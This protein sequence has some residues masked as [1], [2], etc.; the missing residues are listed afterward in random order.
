MANKKPEGELLNVAL[1]FFK[2][3]KKNRPV[4]ENNSDD[5]TVNNWSVIS[6]LWP[7][8]EADKDELKG[9]LDKVNKG[10]ML[11]RRTTLVSDLGFKPIWKPVDYKQERNKSN[12]TGLL[13]TKVMQ[14]TTHANIKKMTNESLVIEKN[15]DSSKIKNLLKDSANKRT[16]WETRVRGQAFY[17]MNQLGSKLRSN[18]NM[19]KLNPYKVRSSI[20]SNKNNFESSSS[21]QKKSETSTKKDIFGHP[22]M[23]PI[24]RRKEIVSPQLDEEQSHFLNLWTLYKSEDFLSFDNVDNTK[25][26]N[27]SITPKRKSILMSNDDHDDA[28]SCSKLEMKKNVR[29]KNEDNQSC[30]KLKIHVSQYEDTESDSKNFCRKK[31]RV[32]VPFEAKNE[33]SPPLLSPKKMKKIKKRKKKK[34]KLPKFPSPHLNVSND[35]IIGLSDIINDLESE[36]PLTFTNTNIK[37]KHYFSGNSDHSTND[38]DKSSPNSTRKISRQKRR[39]KKRKNTVNIVDDTTFDLKNI[40]QGLHQVI[41]EGKK[42][43]SI[44][45]LVSALK[46]FEWT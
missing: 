39:K 44:N 25:K 18:H 9:R 11:Q 27:A 45:I 21:S 34:L 17:F 38:V 43:L 16:L 46:K 12:V 23:S 22:P 36:G 14:T 33:A 31:A 3:C 32:L 24:K 37:N 35:V 19:I 15:R 8:E 30:S 2:E 13:K 26:R 4:H 20:S 28:K 6:E 7:S 10:I 1:D 5:S 42:I 29:I 40:I 41:E